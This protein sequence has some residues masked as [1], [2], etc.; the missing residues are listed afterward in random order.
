VKAAADP[1]CKSAYVCLSETRPV[2]NLGKKLVMDPGDI[3][4][5]PRMVDR[6]A[7]IHTSK[8]PMP[9]DQRNDHAV[10]RESSQ[11]VDSPVFRNMLSACYP[12][13]GQ[14]HAWEAAAE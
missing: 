5:L 2:R 13:I 7:G 14:S 1:R 6:R 9:K 8:L 11:V 3:S 10:R 12:F 4:S